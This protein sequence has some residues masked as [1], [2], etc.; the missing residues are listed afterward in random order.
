MENLTIQPTGDFLL[1]PV[2]DI[3]TAVARLRQFQEFISS[4]LV[5]N[6]DYGIIPG[7]QKPTL[8]KP[9]ADKLCELYGL[10]DDCI[11]IEKV[12]DFEHGLF[13][14]TVK[15]TLTSRRNGYIVATGLGSCN[16]YEKKYR[17]RDTQRKCPNCGKETII[18]G[19]EE[20]G[21]GWVCF[22]KKGG[23]GAKF[24][25]TD[26]SIVNQPIGRVPN[27]DV[28]D[29][30]N[31]ILKMSKKR[32]KIDATL[33]AT[34]S[35]GIFTQ[36]M[37]DLTTNEM[38]PAPEKKTSLVQTTITPKKQSAAQ[39]GTMFLN[40]I[41]KEYGWSLTGIKKH[42][43]DA[44]PGMNSLSDLTQEQTTEAL[45]FFANNKPEQAMTP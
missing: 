39:N 7:T 8:L 41:T 18:K 21:G 37:E 17:W 38:P 16:S 30:K 2:M 11:V 20:Y 1:G 14:Y 42:L 3:E 5:E 45:A 26:P 36:D 27:E 23:C 40:K 33:S 28:A 32:A 25:D 35:S 43:K 19:R 34:R 31:T 4:Y 9:G 6:E 12:E 15:C 44:Y 24:P 22:T 29:L 10:S 13:D